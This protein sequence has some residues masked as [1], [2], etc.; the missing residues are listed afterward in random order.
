MKWDIS[1]YLAKNLA[2]SLALLNPQNS[3]CLRCWLSCG[4]FEINCPFPS[5]RAR[6]WTWVCH[7]S[8]LSAKLEAAKSLSCFCILDTNTLFRVEQLKQEK[9]RKFCSQKSKFLQ[10]DFLLKA[11][12]SLLWVGQ[13]RKESS[14]SAL[15]NLLSKYL[16]ETD[17]LTQ[18][19]FSRLIFSLKKSVSI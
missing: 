3:Q 1:I 15:K 2:K 16:V 5:F 13:S 9:W 6:S 10:F 18:K 11:Y 7:V 14:I 17:R 19:L 4:R 12:L 8:V